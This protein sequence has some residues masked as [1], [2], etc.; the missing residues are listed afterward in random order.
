[1]RQDW[2]EPDALN[3]RYPAPP[4]P[5]YMAA[6][7]QGRLVYR[8]WED[9]AACASQQPR[10]TSGPAP[11]DSANPSSDRE[12]AATRS[13]GAGSSGVD[14]ADALRAPGAPNHEVPCSPCHAHAYH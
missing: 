14:S 5:T 3:E 8:D 13:G 10:N 2:E 6:G 1:M 11:L 7:D 4:T 12:T 9:E